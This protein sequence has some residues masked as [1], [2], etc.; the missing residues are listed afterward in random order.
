[1]LRFCIEPRKLNYVGVKDAYPVLRMEDTLDLLGEA[2]LFLTFDGVCRNWPIE[3]DD[4]DKDDDICIAPCMVYKLRN[5]ARSEQRPE[6]VQG[7]MDIILSTVN[8]EFVFVCMDDAVIFSTSLEKPVNTIQTVLGLL[9]RAAVSLKTKK[10]YFHKD[11]IDY[12]GRLV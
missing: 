9:L 7:V 5:G 4:G 10:Y 2:R 11:R 1:M 6:H 8:W 3:F 12:L